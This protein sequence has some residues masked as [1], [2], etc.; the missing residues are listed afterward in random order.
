MWYHPCCSLP[1]FRLLA[2]FYLLASGP[3]GLSLGH[4]GPT[5][6]VYTIIPPCDPGSR[7]IYLP[8]FSRQIAPHGFV[9]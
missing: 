7:F 5:Y 1:R 2:I 3:Q 6:P 8:L 9:L 4:L